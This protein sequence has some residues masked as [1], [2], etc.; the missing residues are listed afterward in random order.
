MSKTEILTPVAYSL[1]KKYH[2]E[3]LGIKNQFNKFPKNDVN[4]SSNNT[5]INSTGGNNKAKY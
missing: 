3:F 4:S 5:T 1:K 2:A